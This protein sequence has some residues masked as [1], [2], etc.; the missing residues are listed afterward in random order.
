MKLH[1]K[2][3]LLLAVL[4]LTAVACK[5]NKDYDLEQDIDPKMVIVKE[6]TVP[7]GNVGKIDTKTLMILLGEENISVD[8]QGNVVLDFTDDPELL[9]QFDIKGLNIRARYDP[10]RP[11]GL[12]LDL[13]VL[14]SSPFSF[15][16]EAVFIDDQARVVKEYEPL[17]TGS[18]DGGSVLSPSYSIISLNCMARQIVPFDGIR[19]FFHF[20]GGELAGTKYVVKSDETLA[21]QN[22]RLSVPDGIPLEPQWIKA[23]KPYL[24]MVSLLFGKD[25]K[26]AE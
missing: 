18:V 4:S 8:E 26:D 13:E 20:H 23:I 19:F 2:S 3:Y 24:S 6:L 9:I 10:V 16:A 11:I 22:L 17:I 21:F 12:G 1:L 7:L 25:K 14:N 5:V 15:Q